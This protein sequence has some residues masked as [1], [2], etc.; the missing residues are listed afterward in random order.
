MLSGV[1]T[2]SGSRLASLRIETKNST[3][4]PRKSCKRLW[5][6]KTNPTGNKLGVDVARRSKGPNGLE[7]SDD[8]I[9]H[10]IMQELRRAGWSLREN[11]P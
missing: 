2:S 4:K 5:T 8:L 3:T 9:A 10:C 7:P 6:K 1:L 11:S